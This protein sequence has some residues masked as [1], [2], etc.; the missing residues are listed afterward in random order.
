MNLYKEIIQC[1]EENGKTKS[2]V[3][4]AG[5]EEFR[6]P[7]DVFWK[8]ADVEYDECFCLVEV[9][10]DLLVVGE[11][12]WLERHEYDGS[13]W[14]EYKTMPKE[15]LKERSVDSLLCISLGWNDEE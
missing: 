14:F 8:I 12:F 2:D 7:L 3:I 13:E 11:D 1:L 4:W 10:N 9:A 15:P 6:I 5:C